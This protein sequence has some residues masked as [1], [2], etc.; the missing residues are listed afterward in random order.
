MQRKWIKSDTPHPDCNCE[1]IHFGLSTIVF[2]NDAP[3]GGL[4]GAICNCGRCWMS[5]KGKNLWILVS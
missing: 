1:Q 2:A 5:L 4:P 3:K